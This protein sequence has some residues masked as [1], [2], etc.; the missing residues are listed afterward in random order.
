MHDIFS[1]L[2]QKVDEAFGD[3]LHS[4]PLQNNSTTSCLSITDKV[5]FQTPEM[6][7]MRSLME[8]LSTAYYS[9]VSTIA[10][11][12]RCTDVHM[13]LSMSDKIALNFV[14]MDNMR[15]LVNEMRSYQDEVLA[16][17]DRM[18]ELRISAESGLNQSRNTCTA[19]HENTTHQS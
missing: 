16:A 8:E 17:L 19:G 2:V 15:K 14:G 6:K 10:R 18:E 1:K 3:K 4:K 9:V 11:D 7:E 12:M 5:A 13:E